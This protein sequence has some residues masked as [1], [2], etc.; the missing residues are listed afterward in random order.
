MASAGE[1]NYKFTG[2]AVARVFANTI[3]TVSDRTCKSFQCFGLGAEPRCLQRV[4]RNVPNQCNMF[5][6]ISEAV[7]GEIKNLRS[8]LSPQVFANRLHQTVRADNTRRTKS[9]PTLSSCKFWAISCFADIY[10][11][12]NSLQYCDQDKTKVSARRFTAHFIWKQF[13]VVPFG[14]NF[15]SNNDQLNSPSDATRDSPAIASNGNTRQRMAK[16]AAGRKANCQ[17]NT[18]I[19]AILNCKE[20]IIV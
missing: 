12:I 6:R 4:I 2:E 20:E 19:K 9:T 17:S 3:G 13:N 15:T 18:S 11:L 7:V 1:F 8:H 16:L 5:T 10:Q 14:R